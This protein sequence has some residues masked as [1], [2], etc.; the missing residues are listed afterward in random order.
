M[1]RAV[2]HLPAKKRCRGE[3]EKW[4]RASLTATD[5]YSAL[6][7]PRTL[8]PPPPPYPPYPQDTSKTFNSTQYDHPL[9]NGAEMVCALTIAGSDSGG[10]AGIQA[11]LKTFASH[12]VWGISAITAITAQSP[13]EVRGVWALSPEAV[14][15]QLDTVVSHFSPMVAKTGMLANGGIVRAVADHLPREVSLVL[16]PVMIAASGARLLDGEAVEAMTKLL[17]PRAVV[18]TPNIPEAE[19]LAGFS[20]IKT[21]EE[22][23]S[24]GELIR[25]LGAKAVVVKGGHLK[26]VTRYATDVIIDEEGQWLVEGPRYPYRVHGTGC[27]FSAAIAANLALGIPLRDAVK[28]AKI[29]TL[30]AL[31]NAYLSAGGLRSSNPG[32]R[33]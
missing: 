31:K 33:C 1:H 17:I 16:D 12:H 24:A 28:R 3:T 8:V 23:C 9:M 6:D 22:M 5:P 2:T 26:G 11:D 7:P 21:I 19:V 30:D 14:A 27:T 20:P 13:A 15:T 18:I 25:G 29:F 10:G 32:G 4:R